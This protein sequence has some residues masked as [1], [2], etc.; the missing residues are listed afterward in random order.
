[1]TQRIIYLIK[2]YITFLVFF[3]IN[4]LIFALLNEPLTISEF[5]QVWYHGLG[6]D[7]STSGYLIAIPF[8]V[9]WTSIFFERINYKFILAPYFIIVAIL[10]SL[11]C[12]ADTSLYSF[13]NF[14]LD[15]TI[16]AYTDSPRQVL[17]SV[18]AGYVTVRF[19]I[20]TLMAIV[21]GVVSILL[22]PKSFGKIKYDWSLL[23]DN[24]LFIIVGGLIFL[25]IRGGVGRSTM[26]IGNAYFSERTYLNHAAINPAFSLI[27]SWKKSENFSEKYNYLSEEELE[28]VYAPLYSYNTDDRTTIQLIDT[29]RPNVLIIILEGFGSDYV[30]ELGG[31]PGVAPN[32]SRLIKEGVF[33]DN[34]YA[35]S[36]RTDRGLVSA[37]SGHISYPT[38]SIMKIP[39]KSRMLPS[40]ARTLLKEG[41]DTHFVYGGDINFT[42]MR[43]YFTTTGYTTLTSETDFNLK[44]RKSSSWGAHDEYTFARV[45]KIIKNQPNNRPWHI[46]FLTLSS[47]E[48]FEVPYNRLQDKRLNS[49]AYTDHC[50]GEFIDS[51]RNQPVWDNL[52][53][54]IIPDHGSSEKLNVT[55]PKF[56]HI[57]MLWI[58]GV[59]KE[60]T[61]VHTLM[62]QSDM[63]A[64]LLSQMGMS[65]KDFQYSRNVFSANYTYPFAY[66][67]FNDGFMFRDSTGITIYDNAA[68]ET[69]YNDMEI[70]LSR[71]IKGK[72]ILQHS[73][74]ELSMTE[75]SK[76]V[77]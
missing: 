39:A 1:M 29:L 73:Y 3:L 43:S 64:T 12:V 69:V 53:V 63:P 66:S 7:A 41:Y 17:A 26:N 72:A 36:F 23:V 16:F 60:T 33:F 62:N 10:L 22:T 21:L 30:E 50:L 25:A 24:F 76:N 19:L 57:P 54:V 6:L 55:N 42:N 58:G 40:I 44:E 45:L 61:T 18:T 5:L 51:L 15:A 4:K 28:S 68:K 34:V 11:I 35:N 46:G 31:N 49:F 71:E 59:I 67:T 32:I 74:D 77:D 47:H 52:L 37:L 56:Y 38:N 27:Y 14:K 13:W 70:N 75:K 2:L 20:A 48:P 8:V 9:V 65:H